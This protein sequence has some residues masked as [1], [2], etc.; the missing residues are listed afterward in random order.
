MCAWIMRDTCLGSTVIQH[1]IGPQ[2]HFRWCAWDQWIF[3]GNVLPMLL[4]PDSTS[5][6][7][8]RKRRQDC[9]THPEFSM[10]FSDYWTPAQIHHHH[11][12]PA[13]RRRPMWTTFATGQTRQGM[14]HCCCSLLGMKLLIYFSVRATNFLRHVFHA[15]STHPPHNHCSR[16]LLTIP[17][18]APWKLN[19][20]SSLAGGW[21]WFLLLEVQN[22]S[23]VGISLVLFLYPSWQFNTLISMDCQLFQHCSLSLVHP[24]AIIFCWQWYPLI[25]IANIGNGK[26][27]VS[28]SSPS[29]SPSS[30]FA[31]LLWSWMDARL[32]NPPIQKNQSMQML[33]P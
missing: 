23:F 31:K 5:F 24:M 9:R 16:V 20:F 10:Q 13:L 8:M 25:F 4:G 1:Q 12:N 26:P 2:T 19:A 7:N 27:D 15:L 30:R 22:N 18:R 29:S 32:C 14:R 28:C 17:P 11:T 3:V 33:W 21:F 6:P